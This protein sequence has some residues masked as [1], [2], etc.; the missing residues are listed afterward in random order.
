M[1]FG[2]KKKQSEETKEMVYGNEYY[3]IPS[4][5]TKKQKFSGVKLAFYII[6]VVSLCGLIYSGFH[7]MTDWL[8][9]EMSFDKSGKPMLYIK[10]SDVT[11][12][13][14][15]D[16]KGKS[17]VASVLYGT[18]NGQQVKISDNMK[19]VFFATVDHTVESGYALCY[20]QI[21]EIDGKSKDTP[22]E[23]VVIDSGV[24]SYKIPSGG[25]FVLYTKGQNLYFSDLEKSKIIASDVTEFHLSK[26]NQQVIYYKTNGSIYTCGTS[27]NSKP[28]VVDTDVQ[29]VYSEKN[30]YNTICYMKNNHLYIKDMDRERQLV[31]ENVLDAILLDNFLYFVKSEPKIWR[32]NEVFTDEQQVF[33]N[34]RTEPLP[35]DFMTVDASG[36][37]TFDEAAYLDATEAYAEKQKRDEIRDYFAENPLVSDQY[38][39]YMYRRGEAKKVDENLASYSLRYNSC[40]QTIVY[41][42]RQR[43]KNKP[44]L[45]TCHSIDDAVLKVNAY[46]G[47][48][49][50]VMNVLR[51]D[52]TPYMGLEAVPKGQIEISLDGRY[53]YCIEQQNAE[54]KG[55]LVRYSISQKELRHRTELCRGVTE[56]AVD[57]ADSSVALAY[58][59]T[60]MGICQ[61]DTYTPLSEHTNHDFFYVDGTLY[62]FDEY[63][64]TE[65]SGTLMRF[66]DGKTKVVDRDVHTF[67]VRN[68][69][70]VA[71]IKRFDMELGVGELYVRNGNKKHEKIDICVRTILQ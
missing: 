39:L 43:T 50:T 24:T 70:N 32:P 12:K 2:K 4:D 66:R 49:T 69:K 1:K 14:V 48:G 61:G 46:L 67:D 11:I 51:K 8:L 16:K 60:K 22:S 9:P 15:T 42:K 33:D 68:L 58:D 71:Y 62:Y 30:E 57:G 21:A 28:V 23:T 3:G 47:S 59:G 53:L 55:I 26:N 54:G 7:E 41:P 20:R 25:N 18:G 27:E 64:E 13:D 19:Y 44:K 56:F 35:E 38:V 5:Y 31:A 29:V 40:K 6:V 37:E 34:E 65:K 63:N 45:R 10:N 36:E 52:T 17:V